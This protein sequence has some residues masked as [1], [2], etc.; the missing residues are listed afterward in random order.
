MINIIN[1]QQKNEEK[2]L[3]MLK[4]HFYHYASELTVKNLGI[5]F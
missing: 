2:C 5:F 3:Q 4:I 1:F